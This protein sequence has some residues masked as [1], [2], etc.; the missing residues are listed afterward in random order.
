LAPTFKIRGRN[1]LALYVGDHDKKAQFCE[2][3]SV[4][5]FG[6]IVLL[7]FLIVIL[8]FVMIGSYRNTTNLFINSLRKPVLNIYRYPSLCAHILTCLAVIIL[9]IVEFWCSISSMPRSVLHSFINLWGAAYLLSV[10]CVVIIFVARLHYTFQSTKYAYPKWIFQFIIGMNIAAITSAILASIFFLWTGIVVRWTLTTALFLYLFVVL[11]LA[12]LF[13]HGLYKLTL[14]RTQASGALSIYQSIT[15]K[16]PPE[17]EPIDDHSDEEEEIVINNEIDINNEI[18]INSENEYEYEDEKAETEDEEE[19]K[20][21]H[22]RK[23]KKG[24]NDTTRR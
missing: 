12:S 11:F 2:D 17:I 16:A 5:N 14:E 18:E 3:Q 9:V 20:E 21:K 22:K 10:Q 6:S 8:I 15:G 19:E 1:L 4:K 13:I 23:N 7:L 24:K